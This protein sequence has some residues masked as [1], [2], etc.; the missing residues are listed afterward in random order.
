MVARFEAEPKQGKHHPV[1][2]RRFNVI[3]ALSVGLAQCFA[4]VLPG[5]SRSGSTLSA[6]LLRGINRQAALDYSFVIGIPSILAAAVLELKDALI[7]GAEVPVLPMVIGVVVAAVVGFLPLSCCAGWLPAT[8]CFRS[9]F[10]P[11]FWASLYWSQL[12]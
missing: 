2:R 3:D 6:G 12:Y 5:L 7:E 1:G 8:S 4:A 11:P 9:S 10:T